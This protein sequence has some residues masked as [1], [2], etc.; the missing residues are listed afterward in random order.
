[1]KF[2]GP[3][4]GYIS[5]CIRCYRLGIELQP[6][7]TAFFRVEIFLLCHCQLFSSNW[8]SSCSLLITLAANT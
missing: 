8:A 6:G 7:L 4:N 5:G 3:V 1:M 2:V